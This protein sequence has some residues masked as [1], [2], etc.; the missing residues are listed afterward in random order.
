CPPGKPAEKS[1]ST[2]EQ[3][4]QLEQA[5][6]IMEEHYKSKG[7]FD[8]H[9]LQLRDET[10]APESLN[11]YRK[12]YNDIPEVK[13]L[14][15]AMT[16]PARPVLDIPCPL[17]RGF[18]PSWRDEFTHKSGAE[19]WWYVCVDPPDPYANLFIHQNG[20]QHRALFWQT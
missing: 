4:A 2:P 18:D 3:V 7:V 10:S 20:A 14:L 17:T 19:Y 11:V 15:T 13:L 6:R 16:P 9:Y 5:I 8:L 12:V 1:V